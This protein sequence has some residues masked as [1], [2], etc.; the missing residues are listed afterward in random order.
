MSFRINGNKWATIAKILQGRTDN[1]IKNH[2][3]SSMKRRM[4]DLQNQ[5]KAIIKERNGNIKVNWGTVNKNL[6][7]E[8][9]SDKKFLALIMKVEAELL[10]NYEYLVG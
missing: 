1:S 10:E 7:K 9:I 8:L 2:W 3:N 4:P 5:F 6:D